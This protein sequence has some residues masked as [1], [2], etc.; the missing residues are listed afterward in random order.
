M[1]TDEDLRDRLA[2]ADPAV[3]EVAPDILGR[4]PTDTT[5]AP[6]EARSRRRWPQ[7][8]LA[9]AAVTAVGLLGVSVLPQILSS[10]GITTS[11]SS[12][13]NDASVAEPAAPQPDSEMAPAEPGSTTPRASDS[14][15]S[16]TMVRT[17]AMLVGT[18]DPGREADE[19]V[20]TITA[21]G[22]QVTSQTVVTGGAGDSDAPVASAAEGSVSTDMPWYPTGPGIWLTVQ[23]PAEKYEQALAAARASGEVVR[24]QQSAY[25]AGGQIA[26]TAARIRALE[27]SL[28]RLRSLMGEAQNIG[29]VISLEEAIASR[30][31][32]LDGLR[33]QQRELRNQTTMSEISLTLMDPADAKESVGDAQASRWTQ[34]LRWGIAALAL[35]A[36]AAL[37]YRL[38]RRRS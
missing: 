20:R 30:Q 5:P 4:I 25:E 3:G 1:I 26:D 36:L 29:E 18:P 12:Q 34:V 35:A 22:G 31:S 38:F 17:A 33:A 21:L 19:F 16:P 15:P 11:T 13:G 14:A 7:V 32:E 6:R 28:A 10:G 2:S 27:S 8:L 23:V 24:L 9:A 37:A